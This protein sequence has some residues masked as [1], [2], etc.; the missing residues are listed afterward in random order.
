VP[1]CKLRTT[2][3]EDYGKRLRR[4]S[5]KE[6]RKFWS[7]YRLLVTFSGLIAP[8]LRMLQRGIHS[9]LPIAEAVKIGAIGLTLSL[10]GTYL[11]SRR[12]GAETLDAARHTELVRTSS[13][14]SDKTV[15]NLS[16]QTALSRKHPVDEFREN[17]INQWF[18][19]FNSEEI[20]VLKWLLHK[21]ETVDRTCKNPQIY[22]LKRF[23][24]ETELVEET[25]ERQPGGVYAHWTINPNYRQVLTNILFPSPPQA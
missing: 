16:L 12:K 23:V 24:A 19:K 25:T 8:V 3:E 20:E 7:G 13:E 17:Q 5:W 15:E 4:A 22:A 10:L 2:V 1:E 11:Y 9:V 6:Y 14:L 21:S 18:Q